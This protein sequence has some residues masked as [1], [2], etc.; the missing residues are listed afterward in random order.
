MGTFFML[1]GVL[2]IILMIAMI[3]PII[4]FLKKG[5]YKNLAVYAIALW[6]FLQID[7]VMLCIAALFVMAILGWKAMK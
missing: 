5:D 1:I 3:A 2:A 6:V 7:S 4:A